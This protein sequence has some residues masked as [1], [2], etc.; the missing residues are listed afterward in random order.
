MKMSDI[1]LP[2]MYAKTYGVTSTSAQ[3]NISTSALY[4]YLGLSK[5]RR[6][7]ANP[8]EGIFKNGVPLLLYLD[9]FKNFFANTQEDKF[10]MLKGGTSILTIGPKIYQ[11]PAEDIGVYPTNGTSIGSFDESNDWTNY[12]KYRD[13]ETKNGSD[14]ITTMAD[15]STNPT[16]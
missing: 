1:K 11:I 6:S 16:T 14:I 15:L 5:S 3:T 10:Y 12:C 9:I 4:K 2:M 8:T 7:G 13:W